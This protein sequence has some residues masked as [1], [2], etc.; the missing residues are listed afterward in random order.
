MMNIYFLTSKN[1]LFFK[2]FENKGEQKDK[3]QQFYLCIYS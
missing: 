2:K 3:T 1:K